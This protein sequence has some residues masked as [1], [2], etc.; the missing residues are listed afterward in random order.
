MRQKIGAKVMKKIDERHFALISW[1]A[2]FLLAGNK[3]GWWTPIAA[4]LTTYSNLSRPR[5][6]NS[7]YFMK[8]PTPFPTLL[9]IVPFRRSNNKLAWD[10]KS[11]N[12]TCF[13]PMFQLST[14]GKLLDVCLVLLYVWFSEILRVWR[15]SS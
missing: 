8:R 14:R 2:K 5:A 13:G 1:F 10:T 12:S 4:K 7:W 11:S 3:V 6:P 9:L 15:I